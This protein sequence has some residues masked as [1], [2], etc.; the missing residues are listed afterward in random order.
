[1]SRSRLSGLLL[2]AAVLIAGLILWNRVRVIVVVPLHIGGF[3]LL[4]AGLVLVIYL[5]LRL[6]FRR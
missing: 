3:L 1:M 2:V 4:A 5:T 6:I